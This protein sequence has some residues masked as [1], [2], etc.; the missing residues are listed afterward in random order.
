MHNT[1]MH[2]TRTR[3][4][5]AVRLVLYKS[6]VLLLRVCI[7]LLEYFHVITELHKYIMYELV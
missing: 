1:S 6:Y 5:T 2:T 4:R 3:V 7:L